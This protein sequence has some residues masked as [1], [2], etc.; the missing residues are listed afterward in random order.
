MAEGLDRPNQLE[1][2][3]ENGNLA[4]ADLAVP[5]ATVTD[6]SHMRP[7]IGSCSASRVSV[8]ARL[9]PAIHVVACKADVDARDKPAH[10]P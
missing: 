5:A 7:F 1:T 9:V 10:D 8:M 4:Q 6:R 3:D 2:A